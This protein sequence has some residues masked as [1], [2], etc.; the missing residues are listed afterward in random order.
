[1]TH[2]RVRRGLDIPIDGVAQ[3]APVAL[4]MPATIAWSPQELAA[5]SWRVLVAE[6]A[7]VKAGDPLIVSKVIPGLTFVAPV[8]GSVKEIRRGARRVLNEVVIEVSGAGGAYRSPVAPGEVAGLGRGAVE[9][10]LLGSGLWAYLRTRP[11]D[12]VATPGENPQAIL[13]AATESGPLQPGAAELIAADDKAALQAGLTALKALTT[14]KVFLTVPDAAHP[15]LQGLTGVETHTFSGPHPSG[16]PVVQVNLLT[17]PVGTAKVWTIRAWEVVLIGR[18]LLTGAYPAERTYAV[19]G[20]GASQPRFV[21]SLVGAPV[22]HLV[23]GTTAEP[24][25]YI[26]G[27]VLTGKRTSADAWMST[28]TRA[29]HV[30]PETVEREILGWTTPQLGRFSYHKAFL[31]GLFGAAARRFDLRPG[32]W[33]GHRTIIPVGYYNGVVATPDLLPDQLFRSISAGD[34]EEAIKLGLLDISP[35]EA[36]LLTYICPSKIEFDVLLR[37]GL[38][39]YEKES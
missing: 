24:V 37:Q 26:A 4:P 19:V 34:L 31:T 20:K 16:D 29:I 9:E 1:M 5:G 25:R 3:G 17:P 36:A 6:G 18:L 7:P 23:G 12:K 38:E 2:H 11:L 15:A 13:V 22:S 21:R 30:L 14:G 39:Q 32:L 28:F 33:G 27:S 10:A 35:E 8:D